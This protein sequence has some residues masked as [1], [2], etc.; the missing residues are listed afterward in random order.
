MNR[1]AITAA[2]FDRL[3]AT[4][5]IRTAGRKP[6]AWDQVSPAE[7][8]A[9]FLGVGSSQVI[10]ATGQY[11]L[12]QLEF[13]VYLYAHDGSSIGPS[14]QLNTL[15]DAV[16]VSMNRDLSDPAG[17]GVGTATTLGGLV[18]SVELGSVTTDEGSFG[19]R[20]VA[21]VTLQVLA[22]G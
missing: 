3:Q 22:A 1:E 10:T 6:V 14:W 12:W 7:C 9:L 8:P 16:S 20:A 17:S 5:G 19:D 15:I 13:L 4:E 21:V 11:P 18:H 2:L